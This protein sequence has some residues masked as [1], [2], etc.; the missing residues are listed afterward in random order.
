M[1]FYF[2]V[3]VVGLLIGFSKGGLGAALVV[4]VAPLL[5][6]VMPTSE[7]V[8]FSLPLLIFG[9]ILALYVYWKQW[10]MHY[11]RLMLPSAILGVVI[12][13]IM[14]ATLPD[15]SLRRL[16]GVFTLIFIVYRVLSVRLMTVTYQPRNWHGYV[17][18][19]ASGL[20]SA[21]ANTGSPPFTAY[22][23]MQRVTPEVFAAT[24]TLFFAVINVLKVPA[25]ALAGLMRFEHVLS[26]LWV[27]PLIV[28]GVWVGR[29]TIS[30]INQV[31][32]ERILLL[33]LFVA[34]MVLILVPP[35]H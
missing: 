16:L 5:S 24:T 2:I 14:L 34:S 18:G 23:L 32:F 4:L 13:T 25:Q 9:D 12:G 21:L 29:W 31:V 33:L 10:D 8:S 1:A 27:L 35:A 20:G 15:I 11:V 17:A 28:V 30:R 3:V 26:A 7:A 22:M 6:L 19:A